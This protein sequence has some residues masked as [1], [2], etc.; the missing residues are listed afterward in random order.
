MTSALDGMLRA[1]R[2]RR[3]IF[4]LGALVCG[5]MIVT[6][7]AAFDVWALALGTLA[8]MTA[9]P[10]LDRAATTV[11]ISIP[12][13]V[14]HT[15]ALRKLQKQVQDLDVRTTSSIERLRG[16][17]LDEAESLSAEGGPAEPARK[18]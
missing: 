14:D 10:V 8:A 15:D 12:K 17:L 18:G 11:P 3:K 2:R 7:A 13:P 4:M 5:V 16:E 6:V 1:V 9:L